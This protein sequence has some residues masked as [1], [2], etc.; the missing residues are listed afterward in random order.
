M[1]G[2]SKLSSGADGVFGE[3]YNKEEYGNNQWDQKDENNDWEVPGD[4][5]IQNEEKV[6]GNQ[7]AGEDEGE[8]TDHEDTA[9]NWETSKAG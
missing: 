2:W 3:E 1:A 8:N 4:V 6:I 9:L 7:N 5:L